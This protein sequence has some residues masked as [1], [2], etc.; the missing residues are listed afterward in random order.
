MG[1]KLPLYLRSG[2][3]AGLGLACQ[4]ALWL[5][6]KAIQPWEQVGHP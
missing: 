6:S 4:P 1:T 3:M 2:G 5:T